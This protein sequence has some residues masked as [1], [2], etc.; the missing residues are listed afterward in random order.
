[1]VIV[2]LYWFVFFFLSPPISKRLAD[3]HKLYFTLYPTRNIIQWVNFANEIDFCSRAPVYIVFIGNI[4]NDLWCV[5]EL[6]MGPDDQT[7]GPHG[8]MTRH[9]VLYYSGGERVRIVRYRSDSGDRANGAHRT[10]AEARHCSRAPTSDVYGHSCARRTYI[11][12]SYTCT[13]IC[14]VCVPECLQTPDNSIIIII[15]NDN[16]GY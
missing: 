16:D 7:L 5:R 3:G 2:I 4:I 14:R 15:I 1:M 11:V 12:F 6:R 8:K 10:R 9:Y 13:R